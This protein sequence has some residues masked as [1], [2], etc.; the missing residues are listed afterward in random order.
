M[1]TSFNHRA[2]TEAE[3]KSFGGKEEV[4]A[5]EQREKKGGQKAGYVIKIERE[6]ERERRAAAVRD[7]EEERETE[8]ERNLSRQDGGNSKREENEGNIVLVSKI[9]ANV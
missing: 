1:R 2:V 8:K 7:R 5:E 3:R 9:K 6:W 4:S